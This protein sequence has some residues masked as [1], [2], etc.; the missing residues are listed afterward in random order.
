MFIESELLQVQDSYT[1]E[2][3]TGVLLLLAIKQNYLK[4]ENLTAK[5][6]MLVAEAEKHESGDDWH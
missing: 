2:E 6:T 4:R 3:I 1:V 5:G